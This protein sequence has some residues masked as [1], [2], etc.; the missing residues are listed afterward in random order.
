MHIRIQRGGFWVNPHSWGVGRRQRKREAKIGRVPSPAL[1]SEVRWD[2]VLDLGRKSGQAV[3]LPPLWKTE[4]VGGGGDG[5][6]ELRAESE[7]EGLRGSRVETVGGETG[8][9]CPRVSGRRWSEGR[10]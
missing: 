7:G 8:G 5:R 2:R 4:S 10:R 3:P 6:R 1:A 9:D